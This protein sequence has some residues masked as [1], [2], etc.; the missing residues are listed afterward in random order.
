[1]SPRDYDREHTLPKFSLDRRIAV[2]MLALTI[3]VIGAIAVMNIPAEMIPSGFVSSMVSVQV[4]WQD[5]PP[6]EVLDKLT[7]PIEEELG[8]VRGVDKIIS[9]SF[10]GMSQVFILF[11]QS[12]D[13]DV[14]YREVRD[15][16]ERARVDFP[17]DVD[18]VFIR[19]NDSSG[20]PV[21]MIGIGIDPDLEDPWDL[22]QN[23]VIIPVERLDGVGTIQ[24]F[25][26]EEKEIL[27][28][29]D[30]ERAN[31]AGLNIYEMAQDLGGDNF[32]M[33]SG[34]V[35]TGSRKLL[36][37]SM[38]NYRSVEELE[39]R[40]VGLSTRLKDV[41]KIS[42]EEPDKDYRARINGTPAVAIQIVKEAQANTREV[43][44]RLDAQLEKL[45]ANPRLAGLEM[46]S[47]FSQGEIID[48]SLGTLVKSGMF[49]GVLAGIVLFFF[50]RRL[51][52]T[53]IVAFSIPISLVVGVTVMYFVG[54]TLNIL[55]LIGL[56]ICIGLLVDNSVVVAEN[57]HRLRRDGLTRRDAC[58]RGAGEVALAITMSTLTTVIVF[59][60]AALIEG[61]AGFFLTRMA[62]PVAVSV[63]G[64]LIVALVF[65]PLCVY[66]TLSTREQQQ[67]TPSRFEALHRRFTGM[68]GTLYDKTFGR[69]NEAYNRLL[70][71][72]LEHRFGLISGV[73][74]VLIL[75]NLV[76]GRTTEFVGQQDDEQAQFEVEFELP[77]STTLDEASEYFNAI[78]QTME[79][80]REELGL[81]GY[82]VYHE[83]NDGELSAWFLRDNKG[84]PTVKEAMKILIDAFP[85]K[86]GVEILAGNEQQA[87]DEKTNVAEVFIRGEDPDAI[88]EVVNK[89]APLFTQI[90]GVVGRKKSGGQTP[91]ELGLV[92]DRE[93]AQH[94][95]VN[96]QVI[97]GVVGYALRGQSL[98]KFHTDG[99]EVPVRVRF[100]EE[101]RESLSE[102]NS[103]Q[104]PTQDGGLLP[105]SALTTTTML[106]EST[107]I[108]RRD[109]MIGRTISLELEGGKEKE[110]RARIAALQSTIDLPEGI[111]FGS[112]VSR[113]QDLNDDFGG[114]KFAMTLSIVFIY[115]LMGFLFES[116]ILPLSILITI[117]LSSIGMMWGH[118]IT[119]KDLDFLGAVALILLV[120][121]VVNNG[122][123]LIDY[124]NRLR[125]Q[126]HARNEAMLMATHRRFRPIMMTAITT[127]G[128]MIPLALA[129]A[130]SIGLSYTSFSIALIGGLTTA[131]LLTL[132][133][134]PVF[135]T[136][137]DD[138]RLIMAAAISPKRAAAE[139]QEQVAGSAEAPATI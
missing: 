106:P 123:V 33:A 45:Q 89:L 101:D 95:N 1:M 126:G 37:R 121:I 59:L 77:P 47:F 63:S 113:A 104:V 131:T 91:N 16:V 90:E 137:F 52:L 56:M 93:K 64:S 28:E 127:I 9:V 38:A 135:Y 105:L 13:M 32:T 66:L 79:D 85:Q 132:L 7:I 8:S 14:A 36:L 51:R 31:A 39:N 74:G 75:T 18:K 92:I 55:S 29:I 124:V 118:I 94:L 112:S 48:E 49:G 83:E 69:L 102:L 103:F 23:D 34:N 100:A 30:R 57:I 108:V 40:L 122:I 42:Y 136:L 78:E 11:K 133:V 5:S 35:V 81:D 41:A 72:C 2:L 129:G 12:S 115:L 62:V 110:T 24:S 61:P 82:F 44:H 21:Y 54:E 97:A 116:F 138:L 27:I 6:R 15:R 96:P 71:T 17:T 70:G 76:Y 22:I 84:K 119:G 26:L 107:V 117:P 125:A 46:V 114:I 109:K 3:A 86:P 139:A 73:I 130:N 20:F 50:M 111:T 19:K 87:A 120:G 10:S 98:P 58:I 99:R 88:V 65:I 68:L 134:V 53:L 4:P 67:A 43:T 60:P 25:G 80:H 128:G